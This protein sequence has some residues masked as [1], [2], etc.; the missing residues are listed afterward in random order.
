MPIPLPSPGYPGD[1]AGFPQPC[2]SSRAR[3]CKNAQRGFGLGQLSL[4]E[5][6]T[7]LKSNNLAFI[8]FAGI[9]TQE[10]RKRHPDDGDLRDLDLWHAFETDNPTTFVGM[11]Q[12]WVQKAVATE[13]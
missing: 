13:A 1:S 8:G 12:F 9:D 11:Y 2:C 7:F 10:F 4:L 6:K 5:I 3:L